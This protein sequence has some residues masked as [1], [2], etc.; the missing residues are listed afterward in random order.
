MLFRSNRIHPFKVES[1]GS[2]ASSTIDITE[3]YIINSKE[4]DFE[5]DYYLKKKSGRGDMSPFIEMSEL[6]L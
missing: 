4:E 2:Y 1:P 5:I 6:N 3:G